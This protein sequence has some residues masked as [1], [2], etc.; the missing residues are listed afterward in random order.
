MMITLLATADTF[1]SA[2]AAMLAFGATF[3][4]GSAALGGRRGGHHPHAGAGHGVAQHGGGH[5]GIA[6]HGVGHHGVSHLGALHSGTTHSAGHQASATH[7]PPAATGVGAPVGLLRLLAAAPAGHLLD[8]MAWSA[9]ATSFGAVGLAVSGPLGHPSPPLLPAVLATGAGL[10]AASAVSAVFDLLLIRGDNTLREADTWLP[11]TA[12]RVTVAIRAGGGPGEVAYTQRGCRRSMPAR[13]A[14]G[15]QTFVP[16]DEV[17][18]VGVERGCALVRPLALEG[19]ED[20]AVGLAAEPPTDLS[21]PADPHP[22]ER[23]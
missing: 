4:V 7:G 3:L 23:A 22:R 13:G 6:H 8:P 19:T 18:V 10:A 9:F 16:G 12:A 21:E 11:G 20:V 14:D 5:H 17:F 2:C 15:T 1:E